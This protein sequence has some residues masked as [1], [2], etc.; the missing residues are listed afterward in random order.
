MCCGFEDW[1]FFLSMLE[2]MLDICI[3]IVERLLIDYCIVFVLLNIK[4]ML[5]WFDF[6]YFIIEK[7]IN[8]YCEYVIEVILGIEFIFILRLYGWESE[9]FYMIIIKYILSKV[10][11]D[12]IE[13][14]L[15]G[16]GGMVVVVCIVLFYK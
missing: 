16:D 4:S 3:G 2:I 7:Y 10:L 9:I 6:M 11:D 5:K 15:Y 13:Y 12:F 8:V 1:D 14:L